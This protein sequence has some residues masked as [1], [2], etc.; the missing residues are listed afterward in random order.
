M[1]A[2]DARQPPLS[3]AHEAAAPGS[4]RAHGHEIVHPT[5]AAAHAAFH[6]PSAFACGEMVYLTGVIAT[7]EPGE[8][9]A[10]GFRR[11]FVQIGEVLK[12]CDASWDDI[13]KLTSYHLDIGAD[14]RTMAAVKDEFCRQPYPAW[15]VIGAA[16]LANPQGICEIDVVAMRLGATAS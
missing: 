7:L 10:E 6:V 9:R 3:V 15:S 2:S 14:L 11:A 16:S 5:L 8:D 13:V 12:Q 1:S 4:A